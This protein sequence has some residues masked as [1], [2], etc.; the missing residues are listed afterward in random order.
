MAFMAG[1][2]W[3][4]NILMIECLWQKFYFEGFM[5]SYIKPR[6]VTIEYRRYNA[7]KT[8]WV[9]IYVTQTVVESVCQR[10]FG[11]FLT[12]TVQSLYP[13]RKTSTKSYNILGRQRIFLR[14]WLNL[15]VSLILVSKFYVFVNVQ[16]VEQ[17]S[18]PIETCNFCILLL[19]E[20]IL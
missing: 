16:P 8:F 14:T 5:F 9:F 6:I 17:F 4:L 19:N 11:D 18:Q 12:Y 13:G 3:A 1:G 7:A 20:I 2:Y 10:Y 15:F